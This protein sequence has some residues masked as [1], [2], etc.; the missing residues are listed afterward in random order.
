MSCTTWVSGAGVDARAGAAVAGNADRAVPSTTAIMYRL[1]RRA[2]R[3]GVL[4]IVPGHST[5]TAYLNSS[6]HRTGT[7]PDLAAA[8]PKISYHSGSQQPDPSPA[9][10]VP[11]CPFYHAAISSVQ[12]G[13]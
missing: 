11:P 7:R 10:G 4:L 9:T 2:G 6:L 1:R 3:N 5:G 13:P 12:P 8:P